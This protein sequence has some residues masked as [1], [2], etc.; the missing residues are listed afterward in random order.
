METP[1]DPSELQYQLQVM[2]SQRN[3][4]LDAITVAVAKNAR[5]QNQVKFLQE[6]LSEG[7]SVESAENTDTP[8]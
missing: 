7:N 2:R 5:L 1:T 8:F 3:D 6:K 4:A